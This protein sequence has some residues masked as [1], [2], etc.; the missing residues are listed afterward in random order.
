[1]LT[2][3]HSP[4][5]AST[6]GSPS[7]G[8]NSEPAASAKGDTGKPIAGKTAKAAKNQP[9]P[10]PRTHSVACPANSFARVRISGGSSSASTASTSKPSAATTSAARLRRRCRAAIS[11]FESMA[12]PCPPPPRAVKPPRPRAPEAVPRPSDAREKFRFPRPPAAP[13][14]VAA[15]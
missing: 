5:S 7:T 10:S 1:M 6:S 13:T 11:G 12:P 15:L 4:A 8:P 14:L 9:A 3:M 2:A